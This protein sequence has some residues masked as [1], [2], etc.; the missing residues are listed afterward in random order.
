M[1][2]EAIRNNRGAVSIFLILVLVPC[3]AI[4]CIFVDVSRVELSKSSAEASADLAL[5]TL[6]TNY[7]ADLSEYYGLIGSCQNIQDFYTVSAEYFLRT[8]SSQGLSN[9]EIHLLAGVYANATS[10]DTIYDLLQVECVS[11]DKTALV[12]EVPNANLGNPA[13]LK[14]SVVE[15]MKYRA[16]IEMATTLIGRLKSGSSGVED[17]LQAG[18]NEDLVEEKKEFF[19]AES[20]LLEAVIHTYLAIQ[21][22][23]KLVV[24]PPRVEHEEMFAD[25]AQIEAYRVAYQKIH[26]YA[27]QYLLNTNGLGTYS[28]L[29]YD[30]ANYENYDIKNVTDAYSSSQ[31]VDGTDTYYINGKTFKER[32]NTAEKNLK[33][34]E[35]AVDDYGDAVESLL[36]ENPLNNSAINAVQWWV[37]MNNTVYGNNRDANV[38]KYAAEMMKSYRVMLAIYEKC[39]AEAVPEEKP[40]DYVELPADWKTDAGEMCKRLKTAHRDYLAANPAADTS[41]YIK[42]AN[43]LAT[44]S[45]RCANQIKLSSYSV[46][47]DGTSMSIESALSHIT[48]KLSEKRSKYETIINKLDIAI[49]GDGEDVRSLDDLLGLARIYSTQFNEYDE[50]AQGSGTNM[51]K[52]EREFISKE[53]TTQKE[54]TEE[55]VSEI[56]TRLKNIRDQ[57]STLRDKIDSMIYG[58]KALK[59]ISSFATF[60]SAAL[61]VVKDGNIPRKQ[62]DL[63]EYV[64]STFKQLFKPAE[65]DEIKLKHNGED[66]YNPN[67]RVNTPKLYQYM[68]IE[69]QDV[70]QESLDQA[71]KDE[72]DAKTLQDSFE[73]GAKDRATRY[74]GNPVKMDTTFDSEKDIFGMSD[75]LGTLVKVVGDL[76]SDGGPARL[77]D[78][79]YATTYAMEMFSYATFDRE[80]MY[81]NMGEAD[82]KNMIPSDA[83][84]LSQDADAMQYFKDHG[85][86]GDPAGK[87]E[88]QDGM[89]VSTQEKDTFNKSL[90]NKMINLENNKI[91]L[92]EVEY[93]LHGQSDPK[94]NLERTY[95]N[96]YTIRFTLNTISAFQHFWSGTEN[97]SLVIGAT[98]NA[99]SLMFGGV[100]PVPVFKAVLLPILAAV[101]STKDNMRLFAGMPVELYKSKPSD[102]WVSFESGVGKSGY[103]SFVT[104]IIGDDSRDSNQ[105][106]GLY[107]SDYLTLF[108]YCGFSN[109]EKGMYQRLGKLIEANMGKILPAGADGSSAKFDLSKTRMY[110]SLKA[111]LRVKPLMVT[112]PYYLDEY[113]TKGM[114]TATDWCTYK[115]DIVRGYS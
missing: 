81:R 36:A 74:R 5:N 34:F 55:T 35:D 100:I 107:Y 98:A 27:V 105:D 28:R 20:D 25:A 64:N 70:T 53:L 60:K 108:V 43:A 16:P 11:A 82:R 54:V 90:T 61:T 91:Y 86:Y 21:E 102:W 23:E 38:R 3:I 13:M 56:K 89:W 63:N 62:T 59:E 7:D 31:T 46:T 110:F 40:D 50:E 65:A 111:D 37:D 41:S 44:V 66:A 83:I 2:M 96:I 24:G 103:T 78:D 94:V 15:F 79:L 1:S 17:F 71:A 12:S 68:L 85:V 26:E 99:I 115:I 92:A 9:D 80:A 114:R 101:E 72:K 47:V 67:L 4:S 33:K 32:L 51:G 39:E 29:V 69:F 95:S 48:G 93:L 8:I 88:E 106:K 87:L 104:E 97:T 18:V 57:F 75:M 84:P 6:L 52:D 109:S 19:Q 76:I 30:I 73:S 49:N 112:I 58:G 77:R 42:G 10:D 45:A 22:Y 14:D 113:D